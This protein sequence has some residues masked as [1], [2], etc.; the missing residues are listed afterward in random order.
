MA[1]NLVIIESPFKAAAIKSYLGSG[2][3]VVASNGHI[4]DLP[5]SSFGIDI[6]NNFEPHYINI[7]GRADIIN[8]I[9]KDAKNAQ[10]VYFAT[11]PDREGEAISWHLATALGIPVE[12]TLRV[13]FNSIT[14]NAVKDGIKNPR[15]I[16]MNIVNAQQSRRLLD[17]IVGY[18]LSPLLWKKI[19]HGLSA[20]RVQ[21]VATRIIV[22]RE[23][24]IRAFRP[25][26]Y[27]TVAAVLSDGK[28]NFT[29]KFFGNETG[30]VE[31][32]SEDDAARVTEDVKNGRFTVKSVKRGTKLK[33]PAP[34]FITSTLQQEASRKLGFQAS[35]TMKTA[36]ELYE[37]VNLGSEFGGTQGLITY[38]RTDSQRVAEEAQSAAREL[39]TS[40]YGKEYCHETPRNYK[41]N[42][43]AQDAH[44]AIR[45][46]RVELEPSDVRAHLTPDQYKLYRL[47]WERFVSSQMESA[48]LATLNVEFENSGW[49]FRTGGYT[50]TF[51]GYMAVYE[52]SYD[53]GKKNDGD[54]EDKDP[55]IPELS[56][57]Q[58]LRT[59]DVSAQQHFTEAPPRYNDATLVKFLE[60]KGI[61]RPST[62][63]TII[64]TII[65]RGYVTREGKALM[66]TQLG[67]ITTSLMK[68][69]FADIVDYRFTANIENELDAV[70]RGDTTM[71]AVLSS[72]WDG[73]SVELS[74][75]EE[76]LK[77]EKLAVEPELTD[78]VCEKCGA[79]MV[80]RNGR[81]GKFAACPNYPN[82]KNTKALNPDGTLKTEQAEKPE[83]VP[84]M[85]CEVCGGPMVQRRGR[86]GSFYACANYPKC[87]FN[88][89]IEHELEGICCPKCGGKVLI[90]Y[91][92]N[93]S[94]F[95]SCSNYPNCDFST[96]DVPLQDKCPQCGGMLFRKKGRTGEIVCHTDGCGYRRTADLDTA[97][98]G[99]ISER[100]GNGAAKDNKPKTS[101][102]ETNVGASEDAKKTMN[103]SA[104]LQE[105]I[106]PLPAEDEMPE[107][108][109]G[110]DADR[111]PMPGDDDAPF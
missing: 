6:E 53:D 111:P 39:I 83:P 22:E 45:P 66:P 106:M 28:T 55:R 17:R 58:M 107:L 82:C 42:K 38:M 47:I 72:F 74:A 25:V 24:E 3:K 27:W 67:E 88:K 80:V 32:H 69:S 8:E 12:K 10:K 37:G 14:K 81:F 57:G 95:Y 36:Q 26:E 44:E 52:E 64:S 100:D 46:A 97:E 19:R 94:V 1:N 92:R 29:V 75:A 68:E 4:R 65:S 23:E 91:G 60:E 79:T 90:K 93:K 13:T 49:I 62:F 78:I 85:V 61:G 11:D 20:G 84:G 70:E 63:A 9:K 48:R 16:D 96:W 30:K 104:H 99:V 87:K 7:R 59:G 2:Y 18:K 43:S 98:S 86:Y 41:T 50:V 109:E 34:P 15:S 110:F 103:R 71:N 73:F 5:K 101:R 108:P 31:L 102:K 54:E 105:D 89:K 56:E 35:R 77:N 51:P 21:S 40:K 76:K 33:T